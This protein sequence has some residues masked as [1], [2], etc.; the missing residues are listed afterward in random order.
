[1]PK[2]ISI[3]PKLDENANFAQWT[4]KQFNVLFFPNV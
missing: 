4:Q 3:N 1:M 2:H